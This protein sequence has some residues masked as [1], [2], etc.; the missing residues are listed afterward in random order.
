VT[1]FRAFPD[2][3]DQDGDSEPDGE[4]KNVTQKSGTQNASDAGK[5]TAERH[6]GGSVAL[7]TPWKTEKKGMRTIFEWET[8][9]SGWKKAWNLKKSY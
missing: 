2:V 6:G 9:R 1:R 8:I 3:D 7:K 5:S 4:E